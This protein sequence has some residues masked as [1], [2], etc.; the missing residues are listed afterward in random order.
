MEGNPP[1]LKNEVLKDERDPLLGQKGTARED[2]STG[3]WHTQR[4]AE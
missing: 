1:L 2:G 4:V 3:T